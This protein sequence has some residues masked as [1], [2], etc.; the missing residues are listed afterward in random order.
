MLRTTFHLGT[1]IDDF[2]SSY[3][4]VHSVPSKQSVEVTGNEIHLKN[5]L[6]RSFNLSTEFPL[7]WIIHRQ[8][9]LAGEAW[10]CQ[11]SVYAV[12]HHIA[13]DG[14]GYYHSAYQRHEHNYSL[15]NIVDGIVQSE[16]ITSGPLSLF[17]L[18][19]QIAKYKFLGFY[20]LLIESHTRCHCREQCF[21]TQALPT[22]I[23]RVPEITGKF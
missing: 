8:E 23:S 15:V 13:I 4:A 9:S 20:E 11:N 19:N 21:S 5:I 12:S 16:L 7:R 1:S 3:M 22:R 14:V 17:E 18:K 2:S 10:T 6:R